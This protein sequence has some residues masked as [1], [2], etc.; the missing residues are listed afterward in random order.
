MALIVNSASIP[1]SGKVIY[2]STSLKQV[3][4]GSTKVWNN[5]ARYTY[6]NYGAG[7]YTG[8]KESYASG[9][10]GTPAIHSSKGLW[11]SGVPGFQLKFSTPIDITKYS[12]M[13]FDFYTTKG[14]TTTGN[15]MLQI[16]MM[17]QGSDQWAWN[18]QKNLPVPTNWSWARFTGTLDIGSLSGNHYPVIKVYNTTLT[19]DLI[20][21][22]L[23]L[24]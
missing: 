1:S 8:A 10:W 21:N 5:V 11:V 12:T 14:T 2:N 18:T 17:K 9:A 6:W 23:Y 4:F 15:H 19:M 13:Y 24:N 7:N 22:Y 20:L 16:G 3:N